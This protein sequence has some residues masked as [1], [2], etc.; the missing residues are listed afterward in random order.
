FRLPTEQV[1]AV[2]YGESQPIA[3]NKTKQGRLQNRRVELKL[4]YN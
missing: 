4:Y 1:E 3:T 2:G